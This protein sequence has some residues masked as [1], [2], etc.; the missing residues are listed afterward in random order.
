MIGVDLGEGKV[1]QW[2]RRVSGPPFLELFWVVNVDDEIVAFGAVD[3]F[4]AAVVDE[5]DGAVSAR[6]VDDDVMCVW[7]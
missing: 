3:F 6:H 5:C 7:L 1:C 4:L 2:D